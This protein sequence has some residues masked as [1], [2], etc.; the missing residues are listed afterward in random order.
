[1]QDAIL[2]IR[3]PDRQLRDPKQVLVLQDAEH[4]LTKIVE[5]NTQIETLCAGAY[6]IPLRN[7]L[8]SLCQMIALATQVAYPWK[9]VLIDADT[10]W[11]QSQKIASA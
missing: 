2:F 5:R 3:L 10:E 11:L 4:E 1:M 6:R 7:G 8:P 9:A